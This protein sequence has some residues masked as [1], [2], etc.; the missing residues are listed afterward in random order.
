MPGQIAMRLLLLMLFAALLSIDRPADGQTATA[1]LGANSAGDS[2]PSGVKPQ[3]QGGATQIASLDGV[4]WE[5]PGASLEQLKGKTVVVL[6]FGNWCPKCGA[7]AREIFSNVSKAAAGKPVVIVAVSTDASPAKAK[8]YAEHHGLR[9]AN[10]LNGSDPQLAKSFGFT[11][12]FF[13][14]V[15]IDPAGELA[16]SGNAAYETEKGDV[17]SYVV[18]KLIRESK[19]LG[20]FRFIDPAMS[21]GLQELL[22]PMELGQT[23]AAHRGLKRAETSLKPADREL[24]KTAMDR[25]LDEELKTI[26][27]LAQGRGAQRVLA[28]K[29]AA[30]LSSAFRTSEQGKEAKRLLVELAKDKGLMKEVSAKKVYDLSMQT[31]DPDQRMAQLE[32]AAKQFPDTY[33]GA[34]AGKLA[35]AARP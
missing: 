25:F 22:W 3:G 23:S 14:F 15:I 21:L 30:A 8:E 16:S 4:A 13:N 11:N 10:V 7:R 2:A 33:Y 27:A 32:K 24:L 6:T 5:G 29:Q 17:Q 20:K 9:G 19:D 12:E 31:P 34:L 26:Q 1:K 18:G 28:L 35:A